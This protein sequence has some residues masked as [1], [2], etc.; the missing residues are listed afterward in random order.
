MNLPAPP[1]A[2]RLIDL[3]GVDATLRLMEIHGGSRVF[4]PLRAR[5]GQRLARE[6]SAEAEAALVEE[7]GGNNLEVPLCKAWRARIYRARGMTHREIAIKLGCHE[8]SVRQWLSESA[9]TR[10]TSLF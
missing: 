6:L 1:E 10:Q 5:A 7:F 8:R 4:V 3:I 9:D 2:Q